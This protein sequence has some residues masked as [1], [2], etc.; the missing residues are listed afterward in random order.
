[1]P[2]NN[3]KRYFSETANHQPSRG[4]G[5]GLDRTASRGVTPKLLERNYSHQPIVDFR[6]SEPYA[7]LELFII[8]S[9]FGA[10]AAAASGRSDSEGIPSC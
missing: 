2:R 10:A 1:M 7:E 9:P 6:A 3:S 5:F 8:S 4:R